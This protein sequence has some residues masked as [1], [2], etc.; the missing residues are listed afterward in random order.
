MGQDVDTEL[1]RT[2]E[3]IDF[4][5]SRFGPY[6]FDAIGG[7]VVDDRRITFALENQTR[8]IYGRVFFQPNRDDSWVIVHELAHQ[9]YGDSVSVDQWKEIWLNEGFA[10]YAE[11]MWAEATGVRSAQQEF[12]NLYSQ[13]DSPIW[14]VAIGDPGRAALF[15]NAVYDRG[16]L[17]VHALRKTVGDDAFFRILKEWATTKVDGNATTPEFIALAERISGKQLHQL[18]QDWL[19]DKSRPPRP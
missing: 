18:F 19:Y 1:A 10:T 11:W 6:P 4:L 2:P 8:P 14:Q 7:I 9:W 16:G 13:V 3:I 17:T 5:A 12:D 15:A